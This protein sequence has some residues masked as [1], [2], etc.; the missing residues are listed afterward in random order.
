M[1]RSSR[2]KSHKQSK[3]SS[4]E[5]ATAREYSGSDEDVK[6]K[7]KSS[8]GGKEDGVSFRISKDSSV[9]GERRKHG[10]DLFSS[11]GNGDISEEYTTSS[12]RREEKNHG[13]SDRWNGGSS[14]EKGVVVNIENKELLKAK[15]LSKVVS[16]SKS[17]SS[18]R[19]DAE[20]ASIVVL[21]KDEGKSGSG[22]RGEK[23][24][25]EKESSRKES[26]QHKES[27]ESK[28]KERG[29][30]RGR[31]GHS[32]KQDA[33]ASSKQVENQSSKRGKESTDW[34][35]EEGLR[36]P[37]LEKELEK[38]MRRRGEASSD[39]DKYQDDTK[40][41]HVKR[42]KD[43]KQGEDTVRKTRDTKHRSESERHSKHRDDKEKEKDKDK[44]RE[45]KYTNEDGHKYKDDEK[46]ERRERERERDREYRH[47]ED[48]H[49]DVKHR[50]DSEREKRSRDSKYKDSKDSHSIEP[51]P[52]RLKDDNAYDDRV[53]RYKD[54]KDRRRGTNNEKEEGSEYRS[55]I[56]DEKRSGSKVDSGSE[57]VRPGSSRYADMEVSGSHSRRRSSPSRDYHRVSKQDEGKHRE[58]VY[59]DRDRHRG[60]NRDLSS[61]STEKVNMK[62]DV[63]KDKSP[64]SRRSFEEEPGQRSGGSKDAKEQ[65]QQQ[66]QTGNNDYSQ[67]D[68]DNLSVSSPYT[69]TSHFRTGSDSPFDDRNK[70]NNNNRHRR[71]GGGGGGESNNNMNR[72]RGNQGNWKNLPNWGSPMT[73]GGYIPFQHV[74]PPMFHPLMQQFPPPMFGR[75]PMKLPYHVPDHNRPIPWREDSL[76]PPLHGWDANNNPVF[77]VGDESHLYGWDRRNHMGGGNRGWEAATGGEMW[78]GQNQ[79]QNQNQNLMNMQQS[80]GGQKQSD[81]VWQGG[82]NEQIQTTNVV[83]E[84][85]KVSER[86]ETFQLEKEKDTSISIAEVYLSRVDVSQGLT[87]PHVYQ[88]CKSMMLGLYQDS[89]SD[90][91]Q[92]KIL[93]LEEEG[94]EEKESDGSLVF[95]P[96]NDDSVFQK[97]MFLYKKQKEEIGKAKEEEIESTNEEKIDTVKEEEENKSMEVDGDEVVVS[98]KQEEEEELTMEE[99]TNPEEECSKVEE[100]DKKIESN[101]FGSVN[102]SRIHDYNHSSPE[103]STH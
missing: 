74:P 6:M 78:K 21:E 75:P 98:V 28:D 76:P 25:S 23:R 96:I 88:E 41:A 52:K 34:P 45:D 69:R 73:P 40:E 24:K 101:E 20:S 102:L 10:K 57:R 51:E 65:Q 35:I 58:S 97:A 90:E 19:H 12:K 3:H 2:S 103:K 62:D 46:E 64:S 13:G 50:D 18:R 77:G 32:D 72:D 92:C 54:D 26:S 49:R 7:E 83:Q 60:H 93:F 59:E 71:M 15:D 37:E 56:K 30:D 17:K 16:E 79:N 1:P 94:V 100:E 85:E 68:G 42:H 67:I 66:Q 55:R 27:K 43:E 44:H 99:L 31:K 84:S 39:K 95:N 91:F 47:K 87:D 86:V 5:A 9:S 11:H 8:N 36:N 22:N 48:K 63:D 70:S 14:D 53:S 80:G 29:S 61:R 81:E 33:E 4:K 82:E 89:L 38:R